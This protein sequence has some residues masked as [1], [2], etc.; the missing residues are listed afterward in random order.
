MVKSQANIVVC[1]FTASSPNTHV[2]PR[3]GR[4]MTVLLITVLFVSKVNVEQVNISTMSTSQ[5]QVKEK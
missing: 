2:A 3:R 4:R 1:L 5:K